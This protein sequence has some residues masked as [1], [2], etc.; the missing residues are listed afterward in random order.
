[1]II[2]LPTMTVILI[3]FLEM[4]KEMMMMRNVKLMKMMMSYTTALKR[5]LRASY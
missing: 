5:T 4:V 2:T 3:L 1:M